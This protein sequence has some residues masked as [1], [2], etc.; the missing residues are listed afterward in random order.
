MSGAVFFH[1]TSL[2]LKV[3][4]DYILFIY[5]LTAF[6]SCLILLIVYRQQVFG[7][8]KKRQLLG[9]GNTA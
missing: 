1:L 2:G 6:T 8:F 4:G 3:G 9:K 5:A 7:L